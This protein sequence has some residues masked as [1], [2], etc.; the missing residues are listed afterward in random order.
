MKYISRKVV[1]G[2]GLALF[3]ATGLLQA[4]ECKKDSVVLQHLHR[5]ANQQEVKD[6]NKIVH[7]SHRS[8]RALV[9]ELA[10]RSSNHGQ[11]V[12]CN[13]VENACRKLVRESRKG[14]FSNFRRAKSFACSANYKVYTTGN[15]KRWKSPINDPLGKQLRY[16][17]D[18]LNLSR[19]W[20]ITNGS[21]DVVVAVIDTGVDYTHPDLAQNILPGKNF[22]IGLSSE[23][24][25][26]NDPMDDNGHGTHVSGTI[27][28]VGNNRIGVAGVAWN[29]KI[30]PLKFLN[31]SGSGYLSDAVRAINYMVYA[32]QNLGMNIKVSNNSWGGGSFS[33]SLY[34]AISMANDAGILFIAAA[35]NDA[36]DNDE[37]PSYPASYKLPNVTSVA[38]YDDTLSLAYFSNY[39]KRTVDI[40][41]PGLRIAS[42]YPGGYAFLSGTSMATPHVSGALALL[43]SA[44]PSLSAQ[45]LKARLIETARYNSELRGY[46]RDGAQ[47]NVLNMLRNRTSQ[48]YESV[49]QLKLKG[50]RG[51]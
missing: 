12:S 9:G 50:K 39:G 30:L 20:Q 41:A 46:V 33:D 8:G 31:E 19:A 22:A 42:A 37:Y 17:I 6:L 35:G 43:T 23:D 5:T 2:I 48:N 7:F 44:Y 3:S 24:P 47:L 16:A 32:K 18:S 38:A 14:G 15:K 45:E 36:N 51:A 13:E 21:E 26:S 10:R 27:A 28:A 40:A 29:T 49:R 34:A 1:L 25:R 11:D 4:E